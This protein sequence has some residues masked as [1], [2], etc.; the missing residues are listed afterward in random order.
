MIGCLS[1][2]FSGDTEAL[3][4][5]LRWFALNT[6]AGNRVYLFFS[7]YFDLL[8]LKFR[9]AYLLRVNVSVNGCLTYPGR[10][11]AFVL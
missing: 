2:D 9:I 6:E 5:L 1:L 3:E 10:H 7:A 4:I 11:Q 8:S